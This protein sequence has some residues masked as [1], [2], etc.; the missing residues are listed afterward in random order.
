MTLRIE[1]VNWNN[2]EDQVDVDVWDKLLHQHWV[3][4]KIPLS[5]DIKSWNTAMSP[6]ERDV[7]KKVFVGLTA[8]DTVQGR[9]GAKNM[10]QDTST[11]HEFDVLANILFMEAFAGDTQLLT[12]SGWVGISEITTDSL[13]AQYS[14]DTGEIE[15]VHPENVSNHTTNVT[16]KFY[17]KGG[18]YQHHVSAGHR[19]FFD[20]GY[21]PEKGRTYTPVTM[22]ARELYTKGANK[23]RNFWVTSGRKKGSENT[24]SPIDRLRIVINAYGELYDEVKEDDFT[25]FLISFRGARKR[26]RLIEILN[27]L[28]IPYKKTGASRFYLAIPDSLGITDTSLGWR[29][30]TDVSREWALDYFLELVFWHTTKKTE[31]LF[32]TSQ[33]LGDVEFLQALTTISECSSVVSVKEYEHTDAVVYKL[34][35]SFDDTHSCIGQAKDAEKIA[36]SE[37]V[38]AV[39]VPSTFLVTR[40]GPL[41]SPVISGN[42][43]HAKSYSS[44]FSTLISSEEIRD[45]YTWANNNEY[46]IAKMNLIL[47]RYVEE[48]PLKKKIA[49]TL[50][51]SFLFYSGFFWPLYLSSRGKLTNT[52]DIIRL[53][54]A[55]ES[56]HGYYIGYKYQRAVEELDKETQDEYMLFTYELLQDLYDNEVK[57]TR[58]IYDQVGLS[59]QVLTFLRYNANK[60]LANLGYDPLFPV[61]DTKVNPSVLSALSPN[62][63]ESHDFFSGSGSSYVVGKTENLEDSEWNDLW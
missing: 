33:N 36:A 49:S 47:D 58:D 34:R 50:L 18:M 23:P 29:N 4:T 40:N 42:C 13:V 12:P 52:A 11:P 6:E 39:Q 55:D 56:V 31:H 3:D 35:V 2:I 30:L 43:I 54:I 59:D 20:R 62:G 17:G 53:I 22:E 15:F 14:P 19:M 38:Y 63:G 48:D 24:I 28:N 61:S 37:T 41:T 5:G 32:Y 57:Y 46:M 27:S 45:I 16:Y 60:A 10:M 1:P 25:G 7:T 51:E 9:V 44:I 26:E 21:G 8:L